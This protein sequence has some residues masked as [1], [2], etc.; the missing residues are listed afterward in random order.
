MK[1]DMYTVSPTCTT[2]EVHQYWLVA[3]NCATSKLNS[4]VDSV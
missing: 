4:A 2:G 3:R 1:T